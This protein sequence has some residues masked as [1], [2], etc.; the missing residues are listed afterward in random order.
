MTTL[1][2]NCNRTMPMD[3]AALG[4]ALDESLTV[5]TTLC[6][7]EA[8]AFQR[9]VR[10]PDDLVVACTQ[11]QRLF[12]QLAEQ[13]EGAVSADVRPIRFVNLRETGGWG[14]DG[15]RA[16]PK[17]A[18]LL[19]AA[20]LPDPDPVPT[21][22][23]RSAGRLLI[24]GPLDR[25]E[26]LA[27]QLDDA[28]QVTV[29]A[30]GGAG[31]QARRYPVLAGALQHLTGWLGAFELQW[32]EQ[33]PIALDLC[34][35]C[36]ACVVACPEGAIGLDY[37]VDL[38][39]CRDHRDCVSV[40]EA[41]G[42]IDFQRDPVN[43]QDRFDVVLDLRDRPAFTQHA[44]PQGYW[45]LPSSA[46]AATVTSTVLKLREAVGEFEKPRFFQYKARVCAHGRNEQ[47]GCQACIDVCSAS[48]ISSQLDR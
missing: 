43:Q 48:A 34:T 37:Q 10:Q 28:L 44:L 2:C 25:A 8:P 14:R 13:T 19:A 30:Q 29:F 45:H 15:E 12:T 22:T 36:N 1:L 11:E 32:Q 39:R 40:C 31:Q 23:Y 38:N 41:P 42:A 27:A 21:V 17:M 4:R 35:R 7:R 18:A 5:H 9:A 3:G 24:I 20:R 46:A 16:M 47:V 33:N 26:A 6:R